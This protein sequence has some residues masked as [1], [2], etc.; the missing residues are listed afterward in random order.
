M[1]QTR[2]MPE[3]PRILLIGGGNMGRALAGGLVRSGWAIDR[4]AVADP[5]PDARQMLASGLGLA[6]LYRENTLAYSSTSPEIVLFAIKPDNMPTTAT[7]LAPWLVT[8][9]PL[10][11]TIAAGTRAEDLA[12]WTGNHCPV[13][14]VMP[15]TPALIGAGMSA[16]YAR[17]NVSKEQQA[18]AERVMASVGQVLWVD[19]ESLMDAV[20]AVSG[21][22]PAY[23]FMF[24]QA[25]VDGARRM[26]LNEQQARML[27]LETARGAQKLAS[28]SDEPL[29]ELCRKVTSKGG[30]TE[31]ALNTLEAGKLQDLILN[32]LD[33][34]RL[35]AKELGDENS[36]A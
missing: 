20:T 29:D 2:E 14:R 27:V 28:A 16:L 11:M 33:A 35:R 1:A 12:R 18:L 3:T 15:N 5:N 34:A 24:M 36:R 4:I 30:T 7:E 21:S 32:A 8:E 25:M 26:G 13:V 17:K 31:V 22:G 6:K 9:R 10:L 19:R 23:F